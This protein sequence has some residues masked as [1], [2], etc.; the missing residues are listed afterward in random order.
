MEVSYSTYQKGVFLKM[1]IERVPDLI[2]YLGFKESESFLIGDDALFC[3]KKKSRV[4]PNGL[5]SVKHNES[6]RN[7][8]QK[9]GWYTHIIYFLFIQN[10][11]FISCPHPKL[12]EEITENISC[13]RPTYKSCNLR[14]LCNIKFYNINDDP[15][16]VRRLNIQILGEECN[17]VASIS[18]FGQNVLKSDAIKRL[19]KYDKDIN[20]FNEN[21]LFGVK[22]KTFN[23]NSIKLTYDDGTEK[24]HEEF[25][26]NT[27]KFG[28]FSFFLRSITDIEHLHEIF[29]FMF[30]KNLFSYDLFLC[31]L[32]RSDEILKYIE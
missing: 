17:K 3:V 5:L 12:L 28:N 16:Y 24:K 9:Y 1:D 8:S 18:L 19:L 31:P 7:E 15:I 20:A 4:K 22:Q 23:L 32:K 25:S 2:K 11:I 10:H 30:K 27:D 26:L 21:P 6:E 14:E 29:E 13:F